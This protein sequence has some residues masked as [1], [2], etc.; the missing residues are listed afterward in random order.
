ME[1]SIDEIAVTIDEIAA[2]IR[3]SFYNSLTI[4][5]I[6]AYNKSLDVLTS[7]G[8]TLLIEAVKQNIQKE[9]KLSPDQQCL[10]FIGKQLEDDHTLSDYNIR[11]GSMLNLMLH[12]RGIS[13]FV[14]KPNRGL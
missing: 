6:R 1:I 10:V 12:P 7:Y 13:N 8:S 2:N 4:D 5:Q 3:F 9:E 14:K 11:N